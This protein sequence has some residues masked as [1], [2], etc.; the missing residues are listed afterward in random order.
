MSEC[1]ALIGTE[2]P[3]RSPVYSLLPHQ[4]FFPPYQ[5]SEHFFLPAALLQGFPLWGQS[6]ICLQML[7]KDAQISLCPRVAQGG[8]E[9]SVKHP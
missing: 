2:Q 6:E 5:E 8:S 3:T 4:C 7:Q 9:I 1:I